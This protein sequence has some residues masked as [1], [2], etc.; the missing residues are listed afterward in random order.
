MA[1]DVKGKIRATYRETSESYDDIRFVQVAA[2][3][4][5][6]LAQLQPGE[7]VLDVATGT[8]HL[9]L[10][11][12]QAVGPGG[13]VTGLDLTHEMIEQARS[14]ASALNLANIAWWEGD[15]EA[16]PF[17]D[18]TFDA[19]LCSSAIFFLPHQLQALQEWRRCLKPKGR[20]L[21]STFGAGNNANLGEITQKWQK[22]YGLDVFAAPFQLPDPEQS[23]SLLLEAG[24]RDVQVLSERHDYVFRDVDGF[25]LEY[26]GTHVKAALTSLSEERLASFRR[27][28]LADVARL[29]NP[30]GIPRVLA[31][32][33][34]MGYKP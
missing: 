30:Q 29:A 11:A 1:D 21:F 23:R 5:L 13:A 24:F 14:K 18:E 20:V 34:A 9:A 25:W 6:E 16:P 7:V 27:D 2:K 4:L 12:A 17:P 22:A 8:G 33:F 31:L 32:N 3:R 15:A 19:V 28:V 26:R 10:A